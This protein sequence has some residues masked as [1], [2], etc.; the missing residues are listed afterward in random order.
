MLDEEGAL[1]ASIEIETLALASLM[2]VDKDSSPGISAVE[3]EP[4]VV[5]GGD[6]STSSPT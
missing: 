1:S 6:P 4:L 3:L 5:F 2:A